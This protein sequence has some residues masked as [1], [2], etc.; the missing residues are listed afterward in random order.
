MS[1]ELHEFTG[2]LEKTIRGTL[3]NISPHSWNEDH[4]TFTLIE[5]LKE[6]FQG[7]EIY[8]Y[9]Y[10][11]RI[12]WE[13]YKLRG[14]YEKKFGDIALVINISYK[15][16]SSV[17]GVAFLEAKKRDRGKTTFSA[18]KPKQA[19]TIIS[20]APR[21]QYLLYD[22]EYITN[23]LNDS[24]FHEEVKH[25]Y[26]KEEVAFPVVPTTRSV[27]V[28]I[29]LALAKNYKD[30]LLYRHG[31]PFSI[32]LSTRYF[33]G[34]DLEFDEQSK[35]VATGFLE[36]FGLAKFVVKV[37]ISESG[38]KSNDGYLK[39]NTEKY[40]LVKTQQGA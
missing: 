33:Q 25:Y 13:T 26:Y 22:Y 3:S 24:F 36:K 28:P 40:S 4:I 16:G 30:K 35:K 9:D 14:T 11:V 18:M 2:H 23:F 12:D 1:F 19:E 8:G 32:V 15:D 27:C 20:N 34:L 29:N 10:K 38:I 39:I 5:K 21:A 6:D 17:N 7:A 37:D 31:L